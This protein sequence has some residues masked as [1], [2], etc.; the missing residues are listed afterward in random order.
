MAIKIQNVATGVVVFAVLISLIIVAQN[1]IRD[2]YGLED[3]DKQFFDKGKNAGK[4]ITISEAFS[5]LRIIQS[6]NKTISAGLEL[7]APEGAN[8]L[9]D[10]LGSLASVAIGAVGSIIGFITIIFEIIIVIGA[11]YSI[12]GILTNG[13]LAIL[14]LLIGFVI[15]KLFTGGGDI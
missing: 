15:I 6:M 4:N 11:F 10:I 8:T 12:P 2:S 9:G 13:V 7:T 1:G 14:S 5:N 3:L